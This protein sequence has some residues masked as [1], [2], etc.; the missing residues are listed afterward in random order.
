[1]IALTCTSPLR[2]WAA[3]GKRFVVADQSL[4]APRSLDGALRYGESLT[5]GA[6][7]PTSR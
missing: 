4:G 2:D 1:M 3:L 7:R 6:R 5:G